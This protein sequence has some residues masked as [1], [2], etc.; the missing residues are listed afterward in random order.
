M[1]Y[2]FTICPC[3]GYISALINWYMDILGPHT[4]LRS[5]KETDDYLQLII[6]NKN[7]NNLLQASVLL[8]IIKV[9]YFD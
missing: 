5:Q 8:S 1:K 9:F 2:I 4:V 3:R 7:N 6:M